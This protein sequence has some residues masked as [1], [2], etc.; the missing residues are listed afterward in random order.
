MR[1]IV[2]HYTYVIE[3]QVE[4]CVFYIRKIPYKSIESI[5]SLTP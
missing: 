2:I 4:E 5:S 1:E 3:K